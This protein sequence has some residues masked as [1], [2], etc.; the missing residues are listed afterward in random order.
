MSEKDPKKQDILVKKFFEGVSMVD[1]DIASFN[2]FI[3]FELQKIV[4]ANKVVEPTIIPHNVEEFKIKFDKI[5]VKKPEI[6]EADGSKRRVF[7]IEARLRKISYAAPC[8]IEVSA[9]I[10][11]VQRESFTTQIGSIPIML[12]SKYCHLH[13]MSKEELVQQGEDPNDLGG[14]FIINGTEKVLISVEDLAANK[15]LINREN[16]GVSEYVGKMFSEGASFKIPHTM[17]KLKDGMYYLTFTRVRRIPIIVI[18]KALGLT[19][20][21]D[22][23][24]FISRERQF[25][26]VL[27]NLF[28]FAD[29]KTDEE[30]LDYIAKRVGITQSKEIRIERMQEI[31]DK[32][33]LPHLGTT[34]KDRMPKAYNLC[35]LL[36]RFILVSTGEIPVDDKDHYANKRLK[37]SGD[38]LSDLF[39]VNLKVLV[40]DLLY[41]FQRIVKRGKF[42][43]IKVIIRDKL[44]TQR[45]YSSMATG[46]WV[47]GRKGISQRIQRL[48]FLETMSHLQRVVSPLSA[49]QENFEARE[50]HP[51]HAGRLC[52]MET[53]EGT[54]IGLRKNLALLSKVSLETPEEEMIKN[55]KSLGLKAI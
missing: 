28:E 5:W 52:C 39:T 24:M 8:F 17:E 10:N 31:I 11:G 53:P 44:L 25:D 38:L 16:V 2:N 20:D 12:K 30:A 9:H 49:S 19:K 45:I 32:Y 13:K 14:Y 40:N 15:L 7:P 42:P 23:M 50:L 21:E 41:N 37:L 29:I 48:N 4:D 1:S 6:T 54:N 3:D 47:G 36:K 27:V 35:K 33:L 26:S 46:S 22:I 55:L 51:T 34:P 18:I 43:S